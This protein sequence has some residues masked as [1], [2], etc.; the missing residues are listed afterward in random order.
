MPWGECECH[1][2][3]RNASGRGRKAHEVL[4]VR[5]EEELG[6]RAANGRRLGRLR[7]LFGADQPGG[8]RDRSSEPGHLAP[9]ASVT[10]V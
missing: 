6:P 5:L 3:A 4:S 10:I 7:S 1:P 9:D 2:A 8:D